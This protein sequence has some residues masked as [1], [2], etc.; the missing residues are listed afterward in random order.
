[1]PQVTESKELLINLEVVLLLQILSV[2]TLVRGFFKIFDTIRFFLKKI[3]DTI[4]FLAEKL[5]VK[6]VF[7]HCISIETK[8]F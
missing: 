1:M 3:F 2:Y 4:R 6:A 5:A 8:T 7:A